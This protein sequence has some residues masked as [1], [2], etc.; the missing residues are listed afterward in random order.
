MAVYLLH[1]TVPLVM[2]D[3]REVRHYLG[4][5]PD[6]RFYDRLQAHVNN[7]KSA[8]IVQAFLAAGGT[9]CLGN[10]YAGLDR[11]DERRMKS[12]GHISRRC[13]VCKRNELERELNRLR[14][15]AGRRASLEA[16]PS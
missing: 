1:S 6:G 3:G 12:A 13:L 11:N 5:T 14:A 9:L 15:D 2:P 7:R 16:E 4:W 10:Y 8:R